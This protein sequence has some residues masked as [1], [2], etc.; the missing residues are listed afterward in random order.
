MKNKNLEISV[1]RGLPPL[2]VIFL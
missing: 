1:Q 2:S